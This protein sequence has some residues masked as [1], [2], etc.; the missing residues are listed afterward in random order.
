MTP[1]SDTL[2]KLQ[3]WYDQLIPTEKV[4]FYIVSFFIMAIAVMMCISFVALLIQLPKVVISITI[5]LII[6]RVLF[7]WL[8]KGGLKKRI[9]KD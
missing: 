2:D 7:R 4:G 9:Q 8:F 3:E 5:L 6:H 1:K